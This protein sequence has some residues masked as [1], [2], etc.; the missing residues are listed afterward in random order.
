MRRGE[1]W[2]ATL[3]APVGNRPV[4]ILT[5]DAVLHSIGGIVVAL[6]TRTQ[7]LNQLIVNSTALVHEVTDHRASLDESLVDLT[8]VAQTLQAI[9][10]ST[11]QLLD[12]ASPL[13]QTVANLVTASEGNL[14]CTLKGLNP[15]LDL[16]SSPA[17]LK[18]L[19]TLL[20]VGPQAFA[21]VNDS[22]DFDS[23]PSGTGLSGAWLRVGLVLNTT[24]P[25][26]LYNPVHTFPTPA[27][28]A[29]C[30]STLVPVTANYRPTDISAR[31]PLR[32]GNLAG[33]ARDGL[34]AVG[35]G[36]FLAAWARRKVA[37]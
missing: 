12:T 33:P 18:D 31:F 27:T 20:D 24:N 30:T 17:K 13:F 28:V 16:T 25:A 8:E 29:T 34:V 7:A 15:L 14:D 10:P 2:W 5:R 36:L 23:G 37:A 35:L 11:N 6:V 32:P 3:P 22:V 26:V 19:S 9:Q 1:V 21:G 4:V